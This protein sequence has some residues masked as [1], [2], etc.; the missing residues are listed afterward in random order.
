MIEVAI[1]RE[2]F[3]ILAERSKAALAVH[4]VLFRDDR[5][6]NPNME[7]SQKPRKLN[8]Y[9]FST[10]MQTYDQCVKDPTDS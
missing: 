6:L 8:A 2:F 3:D 7:T 1:W 10:C 5:S 4:E 9:L